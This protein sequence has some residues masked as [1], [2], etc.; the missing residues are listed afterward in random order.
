MLRI[1]PAREYSL[2]QDRFIN[3]SYQVARTKMCNTSKRIKVD[4]TP[5]VDEILKTNQVHPI[6]ANSFF[7][8]IVY[9]MRKIGNLPDKLKIIK[10]CS[11]YEAEGEAKTVE[12]FTGIGIT[13]I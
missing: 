2:I 6:S 5:R 3:R 13:N 10:V 9:G 4:T 7:W 8:H 1:V 11:I 12:L